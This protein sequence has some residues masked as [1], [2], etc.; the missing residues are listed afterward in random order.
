MFVLSVTFLLLLSIHHGDFARTATAVLYSDNTNIAGGT[1]TVYQDSAMAS[2]MVTGMISGL[3]GNNTH[4]CFI[5][6]KNTNFQ[7][8]SYSRVFMF[9]QMLSQNLSRIVQQLMLILI[10]TVCNQI[11]HL[12]VKVS[13]FFFRYFTWSNYSQYHQSTCWRSWQ[14]NSKCKWYRLYQHYRFN[15][16]IIQYHT[17]D[18]QS[19]FCRT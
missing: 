10:L 7:I 11:F 1:L 4:V 5:K 2:V 14:Y 15:Y 17:I 19:N 12:K 16:S 9:T 6:K 18:Y 8:R 3:Q 13:S